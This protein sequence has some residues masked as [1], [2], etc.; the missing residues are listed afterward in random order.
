MSPIRPENRDRYPADWKQI[1]IRIRRDRAEGRC[2]CRG[3]C[4]RGTHAGRCPNVNGGEAYGTGSK[5]VLTV[6]HLVSATHLPV[7]LHVTRAAH[8]DEVVELVGTLVLLHPERL[9]GDDVVHDRALAEFLSGPSAHGAR[10]VVALPSGTTRGAPGRS[11]VLGSA[12][13]PEWVVLSSWSLGGP[14]RETADVS[15]EASPRAQVIAGDSILTSAALASAR[16]ERAL[17]SA[18]QFSATGIRASSDAVRRLLRRDRG[19]LSADGALDAALAPSL[20]TADTRALDSLPLLGHELEPALIRASSAGTLGVVREVVSAG[21]TGDL[22]RAQTRS[23]HA[24]LYHF[25]Y[26]PENCDPVN[27]RAMCQGCHLHY[28]RDHHRETAAATRRAAVEAAG[29]LA[30][31]GAS[32]PAHAVHARRLQE[33]EETRP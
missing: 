13:R 6:A 19:H 33:A 28:D 3:E 12:S 16:A 11:V 7:D 8:T 30:L 32:L 18:Y 1:S 31:D 23:R 24:Q 15:A 29:Q 4:G 27:L 9:E 14:P 25:G 10:F 5:V 22:S 26:L 20:C 17:G 2:E 21:R